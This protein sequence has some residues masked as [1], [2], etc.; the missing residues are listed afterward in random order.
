MICRPTAGKGLRT[1]IGI[2]RTEVAP[3]DDAYHT[4]NRSG[5]A[6]AFFIFFSLY[7]WESWRGREHIITNWQCDPT[8][9][10]Y[11]WPTCLLCAGWLEK[12]TDT[13]SMDTAN[14][15]MC[16]QKWNMPVKKPMPA[17]RYRFVSVLVPTWVPGIRG[18]PVP[19][20]SSFNH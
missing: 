13:N 17:V 20:K 2:S 5:Q 9:S 16:L 1:W 14:L 3:K 4:C 6:D 10:F 19:N 15:N 8:F 18:L 7:G 12:A 11:A